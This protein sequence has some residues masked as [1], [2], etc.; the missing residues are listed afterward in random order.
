M[1]R[2]TAVAFATVLVGLGL[3]LGASAFAQQK[4][5]SDQLVG[6]WIFV[7]STTKAADGSPLWGTNPKGIVIFTNNGR[8]SSHLMR[9][10][11]VKFAANS[12]DKGTPEEIKAAVLGN[13]SSFGTYTVDEAKKTV[14]YKIISSTFPNWEGE[15]QTRT[16]DKLTAEDF[17]NTNP[18]VAGGR[19]TAANLYRRV[20]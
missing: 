5:L 10:D 14:T 11:R 13:I 1:D 3:V 9:S 17:V 8:Y 15:S 16:I 7:S 2:R 4:S 12:R 19:G 18:N 6:S 20:K